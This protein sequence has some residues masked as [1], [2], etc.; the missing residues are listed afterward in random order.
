MGREVQRL[1]AQ[2]IIISSSKLQFL[3]VIDA[4]VVM[5]GIASARALM[6]SIVSVSV[7]ELNVWV[8]K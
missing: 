2:T 1:F 4:R 8:G 6:S 3:I 7:V 5:D